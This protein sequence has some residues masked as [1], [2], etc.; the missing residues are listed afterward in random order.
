M[1]AVNRPTPSRIDTEALERETGFGWGWFVTL[2]VTLVVLGAVAFLTLPP[3]GAPSVFAVGILMAVGAFAKLG[4]MLLVPRWRG[5]G[6]LVLSA[7]LY[8]AA[9]ILAIMNPMLTA[10]PLTLLLAFALLGSGLMRIRLSVVMPSLPGRRWIASAGSVTIGC[11]LAF[12]SALLADAVRL[13]G[14]VLASD[15]AFQG[16]MTV[17]FALALKTTPR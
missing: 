5:S 4:T 6:L 17:A 12:A 13:L 14:M 3:T 1:T 10:R 11:A 8:G 2:G 9:G 16:A 15:L 7:V